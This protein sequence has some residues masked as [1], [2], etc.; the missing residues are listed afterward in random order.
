MKA[1]LYWIKNNANY[2]L[3]FS[4]FLIVLE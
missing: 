2:V 1:R 4:Y 3:Y